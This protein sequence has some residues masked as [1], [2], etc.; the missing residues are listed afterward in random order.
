LKGLCFNETANT[1]N[2]ASGMG[3]LNKIRKSELKDEE[4]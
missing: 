3:I 4:T 2:T 1:S